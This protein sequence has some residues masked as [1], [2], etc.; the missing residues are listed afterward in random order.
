M[1]YENVFS[2]SGTVI[3]FK[4]NKTPFIVSRS[5]LDPQQY[6]FSFPLKRYFFVT[7]Y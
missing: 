1:I 4:A 2:L 5:L 6:L 3:S 7:T